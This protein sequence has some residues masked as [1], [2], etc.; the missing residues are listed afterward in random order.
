[1]SEPARFQ[2]RKIELTTTDEQL[3]QDEFRDCDLVW[4]KTEKGNVIIPPNETQAIV[5]IIEENRGAVRIYPTPKS[6]NR[7]GDVGTEDAGYKVIIPW[8]NQW[9]FRVLGNPTVG[10]IRKKESM[11][12]K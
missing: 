5:V 12:T 8:Q 4:T 11:T 2:A 3:L 1:M 10:Y 9:W 7:I 6:T